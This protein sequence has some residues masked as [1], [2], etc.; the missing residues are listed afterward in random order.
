MSADGPDDALSRRDLLLAAVYSVLLLWINAYVCRELFFAQTAYM[1]SMHGFWIALARMAGD[2]WFH[3]TWWPYWDCGIPFEFTYSPLIPGSIAAWSALGKVSHA[4]ALQCITGLVY[5]LAPVTLFLA[6]WLLTRAPGYSFAAAL[7]YSLTAPTQILVPDSDFAVRR[8]WDARRLFLVTVWDDTPHLA[9]LTLLPLVILFLSLAIRK[10]RLGYYI[11]TAVLIALAGL[12]SAFGPTMIAMAAVCLLFVLRREDCLRNIVLTISIGALAYAISAAFYPPSLL[13][14]IRTASAS[15]GEPGF[16]AGSVTALAIVTLGW[17]LLW[18]YLP[19]WTTDWRLQF[20]AL[21]A[22]LTSSVPMIAAYLHRQFLP[23]PGRYKLEMELALALAV[24]FGARSWFD[25]LS[26]SLKGALLFLLLALAGEQIVSHRVYAKNI[27]APADVTRTVEY[28]AARWVEQNL[29]GV[30][31]MMPGSIGQWAN[32]FTDMAQFGGGSWSMAYSQIQQTGLSAVYNGGDT[33]PSDARVSLAWLK[34]FGVGAVGVSGPDSQEFW[35]PFAHPAKFEGMLPVL[36][37][38]EGVTIYRVPQRSAALAHVVPQAALVTR[39][40]S[41]PRD[42]DGI[43]LYDAALDDQSLPLAEFRWEGRNR[44]RIRTAVS[45][46]QVISLQVSYHRGWHGVANGR[47][48]EVGRDGLGLIWL[49][50]G[51]AGV[52]EVELNYDGGRGLR[53]FRYLSYTAIAALLLAFPARRLR[54]SLRRSS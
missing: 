33:A 23:Q 25:R 32:A 14:A 31:V 43:E 49:R 13:R 27:L 29:P 50:P 9:A 20:F 28:R 22:Y 3:A 11:A 51:C 41:G 37:R 18:R 46:G 42:I 36:W 2:S 17:T 54:F 4:L 7:F 44:I 35:K 16:T 53:F 47:E 21:F 5:C 1:N 24:V 6:A 48:C 39:T 30:R 19:R 15:H 8:F 34:A 26:L 12:A 38:E 40:P 45:P 52:C 10:R